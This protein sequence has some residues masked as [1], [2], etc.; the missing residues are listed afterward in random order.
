[1]PHITL[2]W[3]WE[4]MNFTSSGFQYLGAWAEVPMK[5]LGGRFSA[6]ITI[7]GLSC[8]G[9]ARPDPFLEH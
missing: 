8:R 9:S 4:L 6:F 7:A 3:P 1:M 5:R 2:S